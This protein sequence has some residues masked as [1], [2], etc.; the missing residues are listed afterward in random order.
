MKKDQGSIGWFLVFYLFIVLVFI[1][2][3]PKTFSSTWIS[4]SDFHACIEIS[5]SFIALVAAISCLMY[6]FGLKSRYF[7]IVGLGFFICGS[8]DLMHG[9]FS[10]KRFFE[11]SGIDF[12]KFIPGT[13]VAGR[14]MLAIMIIA[15]VFLDPKL[16]IINKPR[17]EALIFSLIAVALG[18]GLTLLAVTLPLPKFILPENII[19]RPVDLFSAILFI[20]AFFLVWKRYLIHKD[21]FSGMLLACILL[22][23]G[24]QIYMSFSKQLFDIFFYVAHWAN[25]VSY[26]MPLLGIS[27]QGLEEI[28]R[29]NREVAVRIQVENDLRQKKYDLDERVKELNCLYGI[30]SLIEQS[31]LSLEEILQGAVNLIPPSWQHSEITCARVIVEGQEFKTENFRETVW[32]QA[33]NIVIHG[34]QI[35]SL[36]VCYLEEMP[37]SYYGPFL[38][39][40]RSLIKAIAE[41]LGKMIDQRRDEAELH[42]AKE[43][44]EA[45]NQAKSE[46]LAS[47]SHEIRTPMNAII[48]MTELCLETELTE[49][50]RDFLSRVQF[51]SEALLGLINDILDFSKIE[52]GQLEIEDISFDLI[53]LVENVAEMIA[54]RASGKE[55]EIIPNVEPGIPHMIMGDPNRLRQILINLAG[56]AV[57]FTKKG[58]I[59]IKVEIEKSD[60]SNKKITIRFVVSDTGIGI[61]RENQSKIFERFLQ[62][63][64]STTRQYG[65]T[66]LGLTI[67]QAL[68]RLMGGKIMIESEEHV[69]SSFYFT[70]DMVRAAEEKKETEDEFYYPEFKN[71]SVLVVDDNETNRFILQRMLTAWNFQVKVVSSG[72]HAISLL[73]EHSA[74]FDLVILDYQM[75]DM[76]GVE[77]ARAIR[78]NHDPDA[79]KIMLLSSIGVIKSDLMKEL[80]ISISLSKPVKQS[81]LLDALMKALRLKLKE[82]KKTGGD[83]KELKD[84]QYVKKDQKILLVEDNPDNQ[85]L[86]ILFM[87][88]GG[89]SADLAENGQQAVETAEKFPYDLILMDIEMPV[90][91]GFTATEKIRA[92]E[93]ANGKGRVPIIALTA[94]AIKGY[95]EKCLKHGMDDYITKP[96]KKK[97]LLETIQ[98]YASTSAKEEI[99]TKESEVNKIEKIVV[100][101]D[102]DLEDLVPGFME[103]RRKDILT[104]QNAA[105]KNDFETIRVLGHSM[106]GSGGGYGF[107]EISKIGKFIEEAAKAADSDEIKKQADELFLYLNRVEVVFV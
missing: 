56:N 104:I 83:V 15:A 80:G 26:I 33:S 82:E 77:T 59:L 12:S 71:I 6:Y 62:A 8:K 22:N 27:V 101:V 1:G 32:K 91:D 67:S 52:A 100:S 30:S 61:S 107:D 84:N 58:E 72:S 88:K 16:K 99:M 64:S 34:K 68:V 49:E 90:L 53:D 79:V 7:L 31:D 36:E 50:Q 74:H 24:G 96:I 65:G 29:A 76:D 37:E 39:E 2:I 63:D 57:K 86:A 51:N 106:K 54:V 25:I 75:P 41:Q 38:K 95:R 21:I 28:N 43:G 10:F 92:M 60:N 40:E 102:S 4:S 9:I 20:V 85:K 78:S 35:G 93:K 3:G 70:L 97:T 55:V 11:D 5:S 23:I 42:K 44:A 18:A 69:G 48:G 73:K 87:A 45:A 46:F 98:K 19:S 81:K 17:R 89:Y 13:Y 14:S 103:N 47:M 94:H 105:E 66:G